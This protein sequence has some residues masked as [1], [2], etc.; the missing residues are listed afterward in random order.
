MDEDLRHKL[1]LA[2]MH[3]RGRLRELWQAAGAEFAQPARALVERVLSDRSHEGANAAAGWLAKLERPPPLL[4]WRA[5]TAALDEW[6]ALDGEGGRKELRQRALATVKAMQACTDADRVVPLLLGGLGAHWRVSSP[7]LRAKWLEA[8]PF[9]AAAAVAV[10]VGEVGDSRSLRDGAFNALSHLKDLAVE[11]RG[12]MWLETWSDPD[13]VRFDY[14][15]YAR[16]GEPAAI[17][18]ILHDSFIL[19]VDSLPMRPVLTK[20]L[21]RIIKR[22]DPWLE[23][24]WSE[25]NYDEKPIGPI[26]LQRALDLLPRVAAS[27]DSEEL[28]LRSLD[29]LWETLGVDG[30]VARGR[31]GGADA[32]PALVAA[33]GGEAVHQAL[34]ALARVGTGARAA[35]DAVRACPESRERALALA[36]IDGSPATLDALLPVCE[37]VIDRAPEVRSQYEEGLITQDEYARAF[38]PAAEAVRLWTMAGF[39]PEQAAM[40]ERLRALCAEHAAIHRDSAIQRLLS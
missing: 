28:A 11:A 26:V 37:E 33:L 27:T 34:G 22:E 10:L 30:A 2:S 3:P 4:P 38:D 36:A 13:R 16:L 15:R 19:G 20:A 5:W 25:P 18:A 17:A 32:V 24:Q 40:R 31:L 12:A 1:D 6:K 39:T 14:S 9:G 23:P 35:L 7:L 29:G 8:H 21:C